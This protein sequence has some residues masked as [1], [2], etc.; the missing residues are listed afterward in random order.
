MN[1]TDL[2]NFDNFD[3]TCVFEKFGRFRDFKMEERAFHCVP[4][5]ILQ[6]NEMLK[7]LELSWVL[8]FISL[9]NCQRF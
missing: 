4:K 7:N 1:V 5:R 3:V 6:V 2:T 9:T 8:K